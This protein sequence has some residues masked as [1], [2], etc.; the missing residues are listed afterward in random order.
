L[1]INI[2]FYLAIGSGVEEEVGLVCGEF[3][4]F[5][6]HCPFGCFAVSSNIGSIDVLVTGPFEVLNGECFD[7]GFCDFVHTAIFLTIG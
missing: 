7:C 6:L 1:N 5:H 4:L 3:G 2:D